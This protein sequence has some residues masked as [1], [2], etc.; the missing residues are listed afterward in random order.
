M[1]GMFTF[2]MDNGNGLVTE[3]ELTGFMMTIS[4]G[5]TSESWDRFADGLGPGNV[6]LFNFD[7]ITQTLGEGGLPS[8]PEG[9]VWNTDE[10]GTFI[11]DPVF[12]CFASGS[13]I[14]IAGHA[15][16]ELDTRHPSTVAVDDLLKEEMKGVVPIPE[17]STYALLGSML[18]LPHLWRKRR[19]VKWAEPS[20]KLE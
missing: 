15:Q 17:P 5:S 18:A 13:F 3:D 10:G 6:F 12:P 7:T 20:K 2:E 1:T 4:D 8:G 19:K 11:C 9:Q 16:D 14:Q